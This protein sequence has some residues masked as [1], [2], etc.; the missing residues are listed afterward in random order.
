MTR[1]TAWAF[2]AAG[3]AMD[4]MARDKQT[5]STAGRSNG[6][7]K[8]GDEK[9]S[10]E[11][12]TGAPRV[13]ID[14]TTHPVTAMDTHYITVGNVDK[15]IVKGQRLHFAF[16]LEV[17]GESVE[18]PTHGVVKAAKDMQLLVRYLAPQPYYQRYLRKAAL[19]LPIKA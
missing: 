5:K 7:G 3:G 10:A 4:V 17:E 13:K 2:H 12:N 19:N 11:K 6:G 18:V 1:A 8:N 16:V 15:D 9:G 14:S